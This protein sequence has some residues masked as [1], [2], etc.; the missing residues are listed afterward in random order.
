MKNE[1]FR[2]GVITSAHGIRGEVNVFPT[3]DDPG[4]FR[5]LEAVLIDRGGTKTPVAIES[6]KY[7]KKMVILKLA[8][9][10]D[11]NTAELYRQKELYVSREDAVP[12]E[13]GQYY[14]ADL[15]GLRVL[16]DT[17]EELGEL[18]DV[19]ETGANDVYVVRKAGK[20][21]LLLPATE[22]CI[23]QADLEAGT[24]T[25]HVLDGLLDL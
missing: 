17:G 7:F 25:V 6:V 18:W 23:L 16:T 14:L 22:E 13:E 19:L 3:T 4:K 20:K 12:L 1:Y 5:E 10:D 15:I 21:D 9:I 2:V 8:G 24:M 11:R